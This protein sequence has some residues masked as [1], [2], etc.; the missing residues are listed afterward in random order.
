MAPFQFIIIILNP[1]L[2]FLPQLRQF[3]IGCPKYNYFKI[4]YLYKF[5]YQ[6]V[7]RTILIQT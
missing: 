6:L 7:M 4:E 3:L 1:C 2:K 5:L